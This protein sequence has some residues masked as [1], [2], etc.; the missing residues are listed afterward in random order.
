MTSRQEDLSL[1]KPSLVSLL[2]LRIAGNRDGYEAERTR[3]LLN[4]LSRHAAENTFDEIIIAMPADEVEAGRTAF[5]SWPG[6][7]VRIVGETELVP[8]LLGQDKVSGWTKQQIIK[9][10]GCARLG[11]DFVL[12]LDADVLCL[13]PISRDILLPGGKT[14]IDTGHIH[15]P[16]WWSASAK[17]LGVV[18]PQ[19]DNTIGV[20]PV[21]L[22][23]E[24]SRRTL[25]RLAN[26]APRGNW[27]EYLVKAL[28]SN[29]YHQFIPRYRNRYR[30]SEY[31]L[32][33]LTGREEGLL[34]CYHARGGTAD[35]PEHLLS[36]N[37]VWTPEDF[38]GLKERLSETD[39]AGLFMVVQSNMKMPFAL[40]REKM[41]EQGLI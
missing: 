23:R 5:G 27:F 9:L 16:W 22:S 38:N 20:T 18:P 26:R 33:Y 32:Y 34:D 30:W 15:R 17:M 14:L 25:S 4:S 11:A 28:R 12:T 6:L 13:R 39:P 2:P 35:R 29:A 41:A 21:L 36:R 40:V 31:T 8:E 37:C 24:I 19:T 7:R 3:Y 10:A 1:D